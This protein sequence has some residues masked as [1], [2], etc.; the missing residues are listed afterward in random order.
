[1]YNVSGGAVLLSQ[2]CFTVK[3]IL[4]TDINRIRGVHMI[5]W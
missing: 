3:V 2:I 1:M 4:G 5:V